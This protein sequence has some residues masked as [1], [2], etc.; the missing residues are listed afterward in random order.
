MRAPRAF[1]SGLGINRWPHNPLEEYLD[2]V[3]LIA[4]G[5]S[6]PAAAR[7]RANVV[8]GVTKA[9]RSYHA[10]A[11]NRWRSQATMS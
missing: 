10:S 6:L 11:K 3:W 9:G 7:Q 1:P 4:R 2:G 5:G 8:H